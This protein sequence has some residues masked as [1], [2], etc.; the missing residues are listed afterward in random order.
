MSIAQGIFP[1]LEELEELPNVGIIRFIPPQ[2]EAQQREA[3]AQAASEAAKLA[4]AARPPQT[5]AAQADFDQV[6]GG[7]TGRGD[8]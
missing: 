5:E 7:S 8:P 2:Y 6:R 4:E 1:E 3:E